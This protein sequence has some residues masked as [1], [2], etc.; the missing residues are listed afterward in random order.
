M[1]CRVRPCGGATG[2]F[3]IRVSGYINEFDTTIEV[4]GDTREGTPINLKRDLG[5]DDN[6]IVANVGFT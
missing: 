3:S 2:H 1:A 4:D 6:N 5:L